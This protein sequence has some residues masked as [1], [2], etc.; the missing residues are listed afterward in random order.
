MFCTVLSVSPEADTQQNIYSVSSGSLS[1]PP[2]WINW[3]WSSEWVF[4]IS[5]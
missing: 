2:G 1:F 5:S 4:Y 3:H